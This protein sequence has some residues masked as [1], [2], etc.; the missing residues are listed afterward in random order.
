MLLFNKFGLGVYAVVIIMLDLNTS[1]FKDVRLGGGEIQV[2]MA[3]A[4]IDV[5]AAHGDWAMLGRT[6]TDGDATV[7]AG[8][9]WLLVGMEALAVGLHSVF[10]PADT[11]RYGGGGGLHILVDVE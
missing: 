9:G 11:Y 1:D 2:W 5:W 6:V 7:V 8:L 4:S 10:G 3:S